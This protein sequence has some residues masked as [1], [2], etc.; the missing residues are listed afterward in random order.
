MSKE[1]TIWN[2]EEIEIVKQLK[3]EGLHCREIAKRVGRSEK[4]IYSK[5]I[6][7]KTGVHNAIRTQIPWTPEDIEQLR[8]LRDVERKSFTE[9]AKIMKRP[10]GTLSS[11]HMYLRTGN[12]GNRVELNTISIPDETREEWRRRQAVSYR[13]LTAA[14]CGDPPLGYSA[15]CKRGQQ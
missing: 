1:R 11:K 15:L 5:L 12:K 10:S 6:K 7:M 4:G 2:V 14:F 3:E 13:D 9:I 8:R